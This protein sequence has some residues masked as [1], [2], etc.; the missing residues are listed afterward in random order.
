MISR[1]VGHFHMGRLLREKLKVKL[2]RKEQETF[3]LSIPNMAG[4]HIPTSTG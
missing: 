1:T 3:A 2:S 4:C